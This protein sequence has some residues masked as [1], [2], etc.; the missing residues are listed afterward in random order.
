MA[1]RPSKPVPGAVLRMIAEAEAQAAAIAGAADVDVDG[2]VDGEPG[3]ATPDEYDPSAVVECAGLDHSDTDNAMRLRRHFGRDLVVLAQAKARASV[4]GAWTGTHWDLDT[5]GPR[6][7]AVAQKIGGLIALEGN[8]IGATPFEAAAIEKAKAA[9]E[10]EPD[11]RSVPEKRLV[12]AADRA[13]AAIEKRKARRGTHAVSSK[14]KGRIEAMLA[15]LAPHVMRQ[16]DAFNADPLVF[17]CR[18]HTIRFVKETVRRTPDPNDADDSREDYDER[19]IRYE[20]R[21]G[22]ERSDWITQ[23]VPV[24][25]DAK[26]K[27]PRWM[28]FLE[29]MMPDEKVRRLLQV[30][31]GLGLTGIAVQYLFFHY[32]S[33]ANGKSVFMETIS[34]LLG[35]VAV[36]LP[37]T[38]FMGEGNSSGS[39]SPDLARLYGRRL[40]RVKELPGN[41][42][43]RE[44]L[45]KELTGGEAL[46]V[47][48]LF[49]GYF[50][51]RPFFTAHMSGN[52][53]PRVQ[54]SDEGIWRR[55]VVIHWPVTVPADQRREFEEIV[56]SFDDE[57]PGILN[58]LIGGVLSYLRDG[59]V[60]PDAVKEATQEYRDEMDPTSAFCAR[61]VVADDKAEITA[62]A[63]YQGYVDFTLDQGGKPVSLT[64]FG[65]I[66]KRKFH[67]EDGRIIKYVGIRLID[68]PRPPQADFGRDR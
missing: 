9:E 22:H 1:K 14:N 39:A 15:C 58:W 12:G 62:K 56:S 50:D 46:A 40:L 8:Y 34:R 30:S 36:T 67:R 59:I 32:G 31:A 65:L 45:V 20:A 3:A 7:F 61:C 4:Y 13:W 63:L 68:V 60:L 64:R 57:W 17:A 48:D 35:D 38:S 23:V 47:R 29:A 21:P 41:E 49:S 44:N 18:T 55:M 5:G 6:A 43:L 2:F 53:F 26:A 37:A 24:A 27:C 11:D 10:K 16:P 42:D 66:M 33:G 19:V 25:Y 51:F 28:A 54:G 52:S